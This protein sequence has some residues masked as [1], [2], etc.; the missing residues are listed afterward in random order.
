MPSRA[1]RR[2]QAPRRRR[3]R[4][5]C[6]SG[7][8]SSTN[9]VGAGARASCDAWRLST[10]RWAR[11]SLWAGSSATCSATSAAWATAS[12]NAVRAVSR[13]CAMRLAGWTRTQN[14]AGS[15]ESPTVAR[16]RTASSSPSRRWAIS[17]SHE[18]AGPGGSARVMR[19]KRITDAAQWPT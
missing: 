3:S 2:A 17:V 9:G 18:R 1:G 11:T 6:G 16:R 5:R 4:R 7:S 10:S 15:M 19:W 13:R 12:A 8:G 14:Q